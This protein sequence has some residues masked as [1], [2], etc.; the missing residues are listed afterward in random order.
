MGWTGLKPEEPTSGGKEG[1][2]RRKFIKTLLWGGGIAALG[3]VGYFTNKETGNPVGKTFEGVRK[4]F[5]EKPIYEGSDISDAFEG[6]FGIPGTDLTGMLD[7]NFTDYESLNGKQVIIFTDK[8][9][10]TPP[11]NYLKLIGR[12]INAETNE[13]IYNRGDKAFISADLPRVD[14]KDKD[15]YLATKGFR[16]NIK[17]D[18]EKLGTDKIRLTGRFSEDYNY[19]I[20]KDQKDGQDNRIKVANMSSWL[21]YLVNSQA[22]DK[23]IDIYLTIKETADWGKVREKERE[24]FNASVDYVAP[25]GTEISALDA[26]ALTGVMVAGINSMNTGNKPKPA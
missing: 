11:H 5:S 16:Y 8:R 13:E 10:F 22:K 15:K 14:L 12:I 9:S 3:G 24:L 25:K 2:G 26:A 20:V 19:I 23:E 7:S 18:W 1:G 17:E 4:I 6:Y 21:K